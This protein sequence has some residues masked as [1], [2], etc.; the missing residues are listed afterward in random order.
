MPSVQHGYRQQVQYAQADTDQRQVGNIGFQA[1]PGRLAGIIGDRDR[2]ADIAP[3]D[4]PS[5]MRPIMRNDS[6]AVSQVRW[7]PRQTLSITP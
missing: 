1:D 6:Q 4:L 3:G 7:T 2:A 5:T